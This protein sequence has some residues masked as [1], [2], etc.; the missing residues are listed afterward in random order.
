MVGIRAFYTVRKLTKAILQ[1]ASAYQ[2]QLVSNSV[3]PSGIATMIVVATRARMIFSLGVLMP[4]I[5]HC[6]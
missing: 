1:L 3:L 4:S 5:N 6:V 2:N